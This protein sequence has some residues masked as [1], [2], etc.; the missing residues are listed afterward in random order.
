MMSCKQHDS[1]SCSFLLDDS[2]V[3]IKRGRS[4]L[5]CRSNG[6][7]RDAPSPSGQDHLSTTTLSPTS[8]AIAGG[9][10]GWLR[11]SGECGSTLLFS[12]ALSITDLRLNLTR[13][14]AP[15]APAR[16]LHLYAPWPSLK[17]FI[18]QP[19]SSWQ[20][21]LR[22]FSRSAAS[23]PHWPDP[24]CLVKEHDSLAESVPCDSAIHMWCVWPSP[25]V[26]SSGSCHFQHWGVRKK[27]RGQRNKLKKA[28]KRDKENEQND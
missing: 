23:M 16:A 22:G 28:N 20:W 26:R 24:S 13:H 11:E 3:S 19:C 9:D 10:E 15:S 21:W 4:P 1:L 6:R 5:L 14:L 2:C 12:I 8:V 17:Y 7:H 25:A 27:K 18:H